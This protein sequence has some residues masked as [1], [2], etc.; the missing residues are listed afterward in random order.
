MCETGRLRRPRRLRNPRQVLWLPGPA[1][2]TLLLISFFGFF[3]VGCSSFSKKSATTYSAGEKAAVDPLTY[4]VIDTEVLPQLGNDALTA[5]TPKSRF[6]LVKI[7]VSNSSNED[8]TIPGLVLVD[9]SGQE[10]PEVADGTNVPNWMGVVRKVGGTQTEQ[11]TILFDAPARHY[12]LR[13]TDETDPRE[14]YIDVPLNYVHEQMKN[15]KT[16]PDGG[17]QE[18][19][20]PGK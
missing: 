4:S 20:I 9:D 14:Y 8:V 19:R 10:Y 16:D 5:R 7:S 12:R 1:P 13:L 18:I 3:L 6:Y 17:P 15:L 2:L 11:G